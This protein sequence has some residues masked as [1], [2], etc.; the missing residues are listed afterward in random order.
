MVGNP[1]FRNMG[2]LNIKDYIPV[3]SQLIKNKG[4]EIERLPVDSIGLKIGLKAEPD[5]LGNKITGMPDMGAIE[6]SD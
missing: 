6:L 1:V 5:I 2:G 4:I 3:N